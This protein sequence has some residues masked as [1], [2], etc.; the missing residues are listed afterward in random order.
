MN[1][2]NLELTNLIEGFRLSCQTEGKSPRTIE[3]YDPM[4]RGFGGFLAV[5]GMPTDVTKVSKDHIRAFIRY[6]QTEAVVPRSEKPISGATLQAYVRTL[7]AFFAWSY[8]EG[9]VAT[10]PTAAIPVPEARAA[11]HIATA[12]HG[13]LAS[14]MRGPDC[15]TRLPVSYHPLLAYREPCPHRNRSHRRQPA[16]PPGAASGSQAA[17]RCSQVAARSSAS[18]RVSTPWQPAALRWKRNAGEAPEALIAPAQGRMR[19]VVWDTS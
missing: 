4:M 2:E 7:K 16:N 17:A 5:S 10:N 12:W 1:S 14:W 9:Y 19:E 6:L 18:N 8:R 3:W 11:G 13:I 15:T